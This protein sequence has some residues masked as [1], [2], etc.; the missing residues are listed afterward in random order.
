LFDARF[1]LWSRDFGF[2]FLWSTP[3]LACLVGFDEAVLSVSK[4]VRGMLRKLEEEEEE[5]E[6]LL[7]AF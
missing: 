7:A 3:C 4:S 5:E 1:L 2:G 6:R